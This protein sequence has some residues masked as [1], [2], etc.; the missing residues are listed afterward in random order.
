MIELLRTR[1]SIRKYSSQGIDNAL[2]DILKEALLRSPSSRGFN[3]WEF[4]FVTDSVK[5]KQ[6]SLCKKNGS[7]FVKN[8]PLA[9]I[10]CGDTTRTDVWIEDCSVASIILQLTAHS[11][12]LGSCWIQIRNRQTAI[13]ESSDEYIKKLIGIPSGFAV[14]SIISIGYPDET[15]EKSIISDSEYAKIHTNGY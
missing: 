12:G 11:L 1:R 3:P 13:G 14:E 9:V 7:S 15:P 4:I 10:I 2:L 8:A 5:L 6:L